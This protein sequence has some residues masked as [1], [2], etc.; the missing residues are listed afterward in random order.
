MMARGL[1][2]DAALRPPPKRHGADV[3]PTP[4]ALTDA[5]RIHVLPLLPEGIIWEPAAG[6]GR[7]A[8]ALRH[9]G[10]QVVASDLNSGL[11]FLRDEPPTTGRF[12][13]IIT[14]P[15]FNQLN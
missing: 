10:R 15:P 11:D 12:A 6:D 2:K 8:T 7:L 5:L 13:A 9:A 4:V 3:W 14:N 1:Q